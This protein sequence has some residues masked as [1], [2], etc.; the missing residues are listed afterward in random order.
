MCIPTKKS[1]A[2]SQTAW[3]TFIVRP[4]IQSVDRDSLL[5]TGCWTLIHHFYWEPQEHNKFIPKQKHY[6]NLKNDIQSYKPEKLENYTRL[7]VL[8]VISAL[9]IFSMSCKYRWFLCSVIHQLLYSNVHILMNCQTMVPGWSHNKVSRRVCSHR[10]T[11]T[12][13]SQHTKI[14]IK[15]PPHKTNWH[16][17]VKEKQWWTPTAYQ[18]KT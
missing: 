6:R 5:H 4:V 7:N 18:S 17:Y 13:Q 16:G 3:P 14:Q 9:Q 15:P 12:T 8:D 11:S 2:S 1:Q 10:H